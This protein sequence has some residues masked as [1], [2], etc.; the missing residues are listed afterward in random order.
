[1]KKILFFL[2]LLF[3]YTLSAQ[4]DNRGTIKVQ[5]KGKI[6][7][8]IFDN[9]NNRLI[10]Q[11]VY[12]NILDSAVVSYNVMV[13]IQGVAYAEQVVGTTL[14]TTMQQRIQRV[15]GGTTLFFTKIKVKEKNGTTFDWR[16][17]SAKIGYSY[18]KEEN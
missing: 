1:M 12:G 18:E 7:S 11:D 8:V 16:K 15:D 9:I 17:F 4:E 6:N 10:A 3:S 2:L 5:K 14:S 13:T